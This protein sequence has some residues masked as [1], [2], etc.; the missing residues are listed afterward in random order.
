M[1]ITSLSSDYKMRYLVCK[2]MEKGTKQIGNWWIIG[3]HWWEAALIHQTS[4]VSVSSH[5]W[6][7]LVAQSVNERGATDPCSPKRRTPQ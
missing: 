6:A 3:L 1:L 2:R 4:V 5:F 7:S